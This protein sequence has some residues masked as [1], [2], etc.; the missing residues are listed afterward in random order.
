[1][2]AA[3]PQDEAMSRSNTGELGNDSSVPKASTGSPPVG[4]LTSR[5]TAGGRGNGG[6]LRE[7]S[8]LAHSAEDSA[9]SAIVTQT[10][11]AVHA[12]NGAGNPYPTAAQAVPQ[13]RN[14]PAAGA[15]SGG[16]TGA[17]NDATRKPLAEDEMMRLKQ[18]KKDEN[19]VF[20]I[21]RNR[22][23]RRRPEKEK[24]PPGPKRSEPPP[25]LIRLTEDL[26]ETMKY[27]AP[28]PASNPAP[29]RAREEIVAASDSKRQRSGVGNSEV[30]ISASTGHVPAAIPITANLESSGV[31]T[32]SKASSKRLREEDDEED[33][34][35]ENVKRPRAE[36]TDAEAVTLTPT[37]DE[38]T[39]FNNQDAVLPMP[40]NEDLYDDP[41][42]DE[43]KVVDEAEKEAR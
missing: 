4:M 2:A 33:D 28:I 6:G 43:A 31:S 21:N 29:K 9:P 30:D 14:N 40:S 32:T 10:L 23:A 41:S 7:G 19:A 24:A 15:F 37:V 22:R 34:E 5:N 42:D 20:G 12:T 13:T 36:S 17:G 27:G 16:Q 1:M 35:A 18:K 11:R 39:I 25:N 26:Q 8:T 3:G 38:S